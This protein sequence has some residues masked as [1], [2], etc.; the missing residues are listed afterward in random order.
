MSTE[1]IELH[2]ETAKEIMDKW[3]ADAKTQTFETLPEFIRHVMNDY[4]HDYGT[5]VHA[6]GACCV[7]TAWACNEMPGAQGGITG[8]QASC[9]MWDFIRHWMYP[10][11]KCG[12]RLIDYDDMLF[13]QY[14]YKFQKTISKETFENLQKEAAERIKKAEES[15]TTFRPHPDVLAHWKSIANGRAPF[16][17]IVDLGLLPIQ[18]TI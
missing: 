13:P 15:D 2:E 18:I 5:I 11:N 8:F 10:G 7:A 1:I 9:V 12:M 14:E 4:I 3:Y 17:Y 6:I 16:G